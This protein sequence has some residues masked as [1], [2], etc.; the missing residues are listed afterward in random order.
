MSRVLRTVP[1]LAVVACLLLGR[2]ALA[3]DEHH[4]GPP[5]VYTANIEEDGKV[6]E[7]KFDLAKPGDRQ[8]LDELLA[9]GEV[10]EL[11]AEKQPDLL[12]LQWEL[13]LW[14]LVI[15]GLLC[16]ILSKVAWGPM[17]EGLRKREQSIAGALDDARKARAEADQMRQ[18]FQADVAKAKD[19]VNAMIEEGRRNAQR[20]AEEETAKARAVMQDE[21]ERMHRE[22][23]LAKD[24]ALQE[25]W[26]QTA[27]LA[28]V[29][30][31]KAI[32]RQMNV[33]DHRRLVDEA[34]AELNQHGNDWKKQQVAGA[35]V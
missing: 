2:P 33:D 5:K 34:L 18:Q 19:N 10:E 27:Q 6:V 25:L 12:A 9:K 1:W 28:T 35:R 11:R 4:K 20:V 17:L 21:R 29:I 15:F 13:G 16:L 14:T 32:H 3:A 22:L 30:S 23:Q 8:A 31:S 26:S 24:Q 7:R